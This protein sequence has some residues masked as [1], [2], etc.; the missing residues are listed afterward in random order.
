MDGVPLQGELAAALGFSS[1]DNLEFLLCDYFFACFILVG[2]ANLALCFMFKILLDAFLL[3]CLAIFVL[4]LIFRFEPV[5]CPLRHKTSFIF[6]VGLEGFL[7][8]H[9]N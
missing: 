3:C 7:F 2:S 9:V 1:V 5:C 6:P 8:Y 4:V